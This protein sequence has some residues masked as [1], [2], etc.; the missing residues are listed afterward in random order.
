MLLSHKNVVILDLCCSD[1][2]CWNKVHL[3]HLINRY[4]ISK[5]NKR[6]PENN[7]EVHNPLQRVDFF[8]ERQV[9]LFFSIQLQ[10]QASGLVY[11]KCKCKWYP[12]AISCLILKLVLLFFT[13]ESSLSLTAN[14][15]V[16]FVVQDIQLTSGSIF[17][18]PLEISVVKKKKKSVNPRII[19]GLLSCQKIFWRY[20]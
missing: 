7:Y 19:L 16:E 15:R 6:L 2:V 8:F 18:K 5:H 17:P 1:R 13:A 11:C 10:F 3:C 12:F 14:S 20:C 4:F 9:V